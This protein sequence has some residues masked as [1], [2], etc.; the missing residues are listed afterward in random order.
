MREERHGE[1]EQ[2][3]RGGREREGE[4]KQRG[5]VEKQREVKIERIR[6]EE[7]ERRKRGIGP[8]IPSLIIVCCDKPL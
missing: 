2:D 8:E 4:K 6:Q 7:S 3:K 1:D 5:R